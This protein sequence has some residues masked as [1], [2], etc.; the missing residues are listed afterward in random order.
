MFRT[1]LASSPRVDRGVHRY[2]LSAAVH[3]ALI[4]GAVTPTRQALPAARVAPRE[5]VML[6]PE[7]PRSAP[8][9]SPTPHAAHAAPT[10]PA[11]EAPSWQPGDLAPALTPPLTA[12]LPTVAG[13]LQGMNLRSDPGLDLG[14]LGLGD[15]ESGD[16]APRSPAAVDEPVRVID[17]PPPRYPAA[18]SAAGVTGRVELAYVVDTLGRAEPG[19]LRTVSSSHPAFEAAARATVLASRYRPARWHGHPVRQLVRQTLAF[20]LSR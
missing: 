7:P 12:N 18:L 19:S 15:A 3:A 2:L 8:P 11:P 16:P 1:L 20:R 4:V 10:R 9:L 5:P 17:Q 14:A 6:F 13:L